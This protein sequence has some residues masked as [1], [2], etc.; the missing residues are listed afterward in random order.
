MDAQ[1]SEEPKTEE[2]SHTTQAIRTIGKSTWEQ[3]ENGHWRR[4]EAEEEKSDRGEEGEIREDQIEHG[5]AEAETDG[6]FELLEQR[7]G[8][9]H[10]P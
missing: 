6:K 2:Q 3:Q 7:I 8:M 1:K 5:D 10:T 9:I 4:K